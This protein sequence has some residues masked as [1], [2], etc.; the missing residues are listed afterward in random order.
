MNIFE[1][2]FDQISVIEERLGYTF[3]KRDLLILSFVHRSFFNEHR[4]LVSGHNERLEFLGDSVLGLII[5]DYLYE[6]LPDHEEGQLSHLRSHLV[7]A[8]SCV[9]YFCKLALENYALLGRG[10]RMN[11]GRGR[12]SILADMFEALIGAIYL[13][14]GLEEVKVFFFRHFYDAV[15]VALKQPLR[16]WK[17]ELQDYSQKRYQRPP[18]YKVLKESGPDHS[19]IFEVVAYIEDKEVGIGSGSSKKQA[20]QA[21]AQNALNNLEE[22]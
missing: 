3:K 20:E 14:G 10:E 8:G 22:G 2:L 9:N 11:D 16:N 4:D 1:K 18:I 17:A 6:Y 12:D 5:S 13:D 15:E 19:K 7:E 21:A